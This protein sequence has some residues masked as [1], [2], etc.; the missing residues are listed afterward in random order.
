VG[1]SDERDFAIP[2]PP[3]AE[4]GTHFDFPEHKNSMDSGSPLARRPE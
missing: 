2:G 3:K 4:P 1:K